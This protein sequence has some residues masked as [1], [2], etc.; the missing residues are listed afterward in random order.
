MNRF[1]LSD[2]HL[3]HNNI[4]SFL[5]NDGER[6]R[7]WAETAEQSDEMMIEA[8]NAVVKAGDTVYFMGDVAIRAKALSLLTRM[9]GRKI[10][11]RGNHDI[12]KM[13]Q[14]AEHFADIRATHL[15]DKLLISHY[16]LH[17]SS[18][19]EW[20]IGNAHGHTH[21][22]PVLGP[23]GTPDP[24]Y[25]NLCVEAV[26]LTPLTVEEVCDRLMRAQ[27]VLNLNI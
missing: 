21:E 19:P 4:Y 16:P 25:I 23:D 17:P 27:T 3:G 5:G 14:Y 12:F 24:R 8:H 20:A 15:L 26:G 22:K 1:L 9:N 2:H 10:L 18:V 11:I 6:I 13:K 7:P